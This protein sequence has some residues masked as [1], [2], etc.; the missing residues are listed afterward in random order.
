MTYYLKVERRQLH[1]Y[2]MLSYTM[3]CSALSIL[4]QLAKKPK[5]MRHYK[6]CSKKLTPAAWAKLGQMF[7]SKGSFPQYG[8]VRGL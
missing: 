5:A 4:P 2:H 1:S 3:N 6:P 8:K 7:W